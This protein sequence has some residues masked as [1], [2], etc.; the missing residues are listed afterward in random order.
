MPLLRISCRSFRSDQRILGPGKRGCC[1]IRPSFTDQAG[2]RR[3]SASILQ[4]RKTTQA[5]GLPPLAGAAVGPGGGLVEAKELYRAKALF[6]LGSGLLA[7]IRDFAVLLDRI[8]LDLEDPRS[9]VPGLSFGCCP[10]C[11]A[12]LWDRPL[13]SSFCDQFDHK[14]GVRLGRV[15]PAQ[16]SFQAVGLALTR[17]LCRGLRGLVKTDERF[18]AFVPVLPVGSKDPRAGEKRLLPYP[19]FFHGPGRGSAV[20]RLDPSSEKNNS[21]RRLAPVSRG[22]CRSRR[23]VG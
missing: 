13:D 15:R 14:E 17:P 12:V 11:A 16:G 20:F 23:G 1:L 7:V 2:G 5:V 10:V 6:A 3:C 9:L 22:R 19:A 8:D 4:A 18:Q 21:S